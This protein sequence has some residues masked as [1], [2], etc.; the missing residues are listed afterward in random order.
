MTGIANTYLNS[1]NQPSSKGI[2]VPLNKHNM[3]EGRFTNQSPDQAPGLSMGM[4]ALNIQDNTEM[5]A[6]AVSRDL[7]SLPTELI[8][9]MVEHLPQDHDTVQ[10]GY[11]GSDALRSAQ[12]GIEALCRVSRQM[13]AM[14][15]PQLYR[16]IVVS[17]PYKLHH[18]RKTLD[19]SPELG[20]NV[21][22]LT[23]YRDL[24]SSDIEDQELLNSGHHDPQTITLSQFSETLVAVLKKTPNLVTLSLNFD[25]TTVFRESNH[26]DLLKRFIPT[27]IKR[28]KN[29]DGLQTFLPK[30]AKLGIL[31]PQGWGS[32]IDR[33][34]EY[35]TFEDLLNLPSLSHIVVR[36]PGPGFCP[37][38]E[39]Y[40]E[41]LSK[42]LSHQESFGSAATNS[43]ISCR[44]EKM[45]LTRNCS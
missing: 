11:A 12:A 42:S 13:L 25:K 18:L 29:A 41:F 26:F 9:E 44:Q 37:G 23:V 16:T 6:H 2:K 21:T 33:S 27:E 3:A 14:A 40:G 1:N 7:A 35:Q 43:Y 24:E 15:K 10:V 45:Q 19:G 32:R 36:R 38:H 28:A 17:D 5:D 39:S 34:D 8:L 22:S 30:V 20:A 31:L 4:G